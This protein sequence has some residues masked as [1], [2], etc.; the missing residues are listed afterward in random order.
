[1]SLQMLRVIVCSLEANIISDCKYL[2]TFQ[3]YLDTVFQTKW[4]QV[5][6]ISAT[7]FRDKIIKLIINRRRICVQFVQYKFISIYALPSSHL[8]KSHNI[9]NSL[10]HQLSLPAACFVALM[11]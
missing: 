9:N 6:A 11:A 1:M 3:F 8:I 2:I 4:M 7:R 5:I 10:L